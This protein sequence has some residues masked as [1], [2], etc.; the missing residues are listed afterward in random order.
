MKISRGSLTEFINSQFVFEVLSCLFDLRDL[1]KVV[2]GLS[3]MNKI[4]MSHLELRLLISPVIILG[5]FQNFQIWIS[6]HG[7]SLK[8]N[9]TL[10]GCSHQ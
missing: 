4:E 7:M 3:K 1:I 10:V 5:T 8:L 6:S 2:P 9:H